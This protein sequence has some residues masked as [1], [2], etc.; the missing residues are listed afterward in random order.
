MQWSWKHCAIATAIH[1]CCSLTQQQEMTCRFWHETKGFGKLC[2]SVQINTFVPEEQRW[3]N[4]TSWQKFNCNYLVMLPPQSLCTWIIFT[5]SLNCIHQ[6][7]TFSYKG[8]IFSVWHD[9]MVLLLSLCYTGLCIFLGLF[10][11][12]SEQQRDHLLA[13]V[14]SASFY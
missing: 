7:C 8:V 6:S 13:F 9:E 5:V 11:R 10:W 4:D 12:W 1:N 3:W 2:A 14:C